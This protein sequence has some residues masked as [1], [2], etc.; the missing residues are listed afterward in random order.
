MQSL[1]SV[2]NSS[3][4]NTN[5]PAIQK[6]TVPF[7]GQVQEFKPEEKQSN[8][9]L[10]K[11]LGAAAVA[12]L[13]GAS[14]KT[15]DVNKALKE[16]GLKDTSK[17]GLSDI[18]LRNLNPINW[19]EKS[20]A[21]QKLTDIN[22]TK[23]GDSGRLFQTKDGDTLLLDR[24]RV[25]KIKSG[26]GEDVEE[27]AKKATPTTSTATKTEAKVEEKA[28]QQITH[29]VN[30]QLVTDIKALPQEINQK[31]AQKLSHLLLKDM[32]FNP[33]ELGLTVRAGSAKEM[34]G[35]LARFDMKSG[36]V[37]VGE[38][39]LQSGGRASITDV[40]PILRHELDHAEKM[41]KTAK[42]IGVDE[43]EKFTAS[44]PDLPEAQFNKFF[45]EHA[46]KNINA[47]GFDHKPYTEGLKAQILGL[48]PTQYDSAK[49]MASYI[50]NPLEQ[51]AHK[52]QHEF[53][54]A[55]KVKGKIATMEPVAE[56]FPK[57]DAALDSYTKK[58][59]VSADLKP[60]LYSY[61]QEIESA[62][63]LEQSENPQIGQRLLQSPDN[64]AKIMEN[65]I[66]AMDSTPLT[67]EIVSDA[68]FITTNHQAQMLQT[69]QIT[70]EYKTKMLEIFGKNNDEYLEQNQT[71]DPTKEM[72]ALAR[73][74]HIINNG[75]ITGVR[76][77]MRGLEDISIPAEIKDRITKNSAFQ[78]AISNTQ[79][80]PENQAQNLTPAQYEDSVM[81]S[82]L[83]TTKLSEF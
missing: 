4:I 6:Q 78:E 62:K 29:T 70:G 27:F 42:V 21:V 68:H 31:N 46:T 54:A 63:F 28:A 16:A 33:Q 19:L 74:I 73:K 66:K 51:S 36:E 24:S 79:K 22:C 75:E 17:I 44:L 76:L 81:L 53:E 25:F 34:T 18:F 59:S 71:L 10:L 41:I 52:I 58:H 83:Q 50:S 13:A 12:I 80:I 7:K 56:V 49:A 11:V 5:Q 48:L 37:L 39:I 30:P 3:V 35:A 43:Y 72:V 2:S 77:G 38:N 1:N 26:E 61:F 55:L 60:K 14:H 9:T 40:A 65:M 45:W 64:Q 47:E 57:V 32:G 8:N 15:Y 82:L 23:I 20:E 69:G 67:P